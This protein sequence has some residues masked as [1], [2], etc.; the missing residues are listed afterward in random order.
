[1]KFEL[2]PSRTKGRRLWSNLSLRPKTLILWPGPSNQ[3]LKVRLI[4]TDL[5]ASLLLPRLFQVL[6]SQ[7]ESPFKSSTWS[8]RF[9]SWRETMQMQKKTLT[10]NSLLIWRT[11]RITSW[12]GSLSR[13]PQLWFL[14]S[15]L[16]F[17]CPQELRSHK[18]CQYLN[19]STHKFLLQSSLL[20]K[21]LLKTLWCLQFHQYLSFNNSSLPHKYHKVCLFHLNYLP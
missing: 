2:K 10:L 6:R 1:M 15:L 17:R 4:S 20:L 18:E 8:R 7:K 14:V 21:C 16:N 9:K 3:T 5:I 12:G 13:N 19:S 11:L